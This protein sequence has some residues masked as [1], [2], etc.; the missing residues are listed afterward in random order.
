M[1]IVNFKGKLRGDYEIYEKDPHPKFKQFRD[2]IYF[3]TKKGLENKKT[4]SI[5]VW[6][7]DMNR[8]LITD[9]PTLTTKLTV[10]EPILTINTKE[11]VDMNI[12]DSYDF[13]QPL[14]DSEDQLIEDSYVAFRRFDTDTDKRIVSVRQMNNLDKSLALFKFKDH[15]ERLITS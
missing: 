6:K 3:M 5:T 14:E 1:E 12:I 4:E 2:Y 8:Q 9:C 7:L 10:K 13:I 15:I 11:L